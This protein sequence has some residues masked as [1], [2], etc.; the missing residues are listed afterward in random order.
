M[1]KTK[2]EKEWYFNKLH[3]HDEGHLFKISDDFSNIIN[4]DVR[5]LFII[6]ND[7][8]KFE[9][10]VYYLHLY[11]DTLTIHLWRE[12]VNGA[13]LEINSQ[14][15]CKGKS[16]EFLSSYYGINLDRCLSFGDGDNDVE[17]LKPSCHSFAMK[18]ATDAAKVY[19]RYITKYDNDNC[20]VAKELINFFDLKGFTNKKAKNG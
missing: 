18:N 19:A 1:P 16:L 20:G 7:T 2:S 11:S 5:I 8:S 14:F 17:M 15:A 4:T 9:E 6:L 10:V 13:V 3:I 12:N